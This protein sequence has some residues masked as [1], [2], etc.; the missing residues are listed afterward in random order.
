MT[1]IIYLILI[2]YSGRDD[3]KLNVWMFSKMI[4]HNSKKSQ[5]F[6]R[7]QYQLHTI[8]SSPHL[9]RVQYHQ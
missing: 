3:W 8:G 2:Q 4:G 7:A 6:L 1:T 9:C 5:E